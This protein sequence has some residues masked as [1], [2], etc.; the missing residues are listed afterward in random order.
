MNTLFREALLNLETMFLLIE[1]DKLMK[2]T[3]KLQK[4]YIAV[5]KKGKDSLVLEE[6]MN[7][8]SL[9]DVLNEWERLMKE[10]LKEYRERI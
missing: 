3:K 9:V 2:R 4:E 1:E 5:I 8:S 7:I 6:E 10:N